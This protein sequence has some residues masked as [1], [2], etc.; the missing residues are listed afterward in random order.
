M[1]FLSPIVHQPFAN[2]PHFYYIGHIVAVATNY[3][4]LLYIPIF[5]K[6]LPI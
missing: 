1:L 3:S 2:Q 6:S 4:N 5:Y